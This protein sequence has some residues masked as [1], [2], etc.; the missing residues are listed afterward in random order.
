MNELASAGIDKGYDAPQLENL[1]NDMCF[2]NNNVKLSIQGDGY[3]NRFRIFPLSVKIDSDGLV[4]FTLDGLENLEDNQKIYIYDAI[5]NEYYN[6]KNEPFTVNLQSGIMDNRFSLCFKRNANSN[7][8][9]ESSTSVDVSLVNHNKTIIIAKN[10][11]D[12]VVQSATL[13][14]MLG[15]FIVEWKLNE[16]NQDQFVEIPVNDIS[17]GTYILKINTSNGNVG[18]KVIIH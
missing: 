15:Q 13:Y 10:D 3:F 7:N 12:T 9:T 18:K 1:T 4:K 2:I 6:I 11:A 8:K 17:Q 16:S 14:N 5:A